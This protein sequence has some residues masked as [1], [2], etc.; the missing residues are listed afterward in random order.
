MTSNLDDSEAEAGLVNLTG[1][2]ADLFADDTQLELAQLEATVHP[3]LTIPPEIMAEIFCH[4]AAISPNKWPL[5]ATSVCTAWRSIASATPHLWNTFHETITARPREPFR[6]LQLWIF[7]SGSLPLDLTITVSHD[8]ELRRLLASTVS[9][10]R[11]VELFGALCFESLRDAERPRRL[12]ALAL[13][14]NI[15]LAKVDSD[16]WPQWRSLVI[17]GVTL[18]PTPILPALSHVTSLTLKRVTAAVAW[19]VLAH[20][21]AVKFLSLYGNHLHHPPS[22]GILTVVLPRVHTLYDGAP[23]IL[24]HLTLPGLRDLR[25]TG[26]T[27]PSPGELEPFLNRSNCT[28]RSVY[29]ED[30]DNFLTLSCLCAIPSV[31]EFTGQ[32]V[33]LDGDEDG[34]ERIREFLAAFAAG[35]VLPN[36]EQMTL[37][38]IPHGIIPHLHPTFSNKLRLPMSRLK[39][40]TVDI[41]GDDG[42]PDELRSALAEGGVELKVLFT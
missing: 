1:Q 28:L 10:W 15:P 39:K 34:E 19:Q 38:G 37:L 8:E 24:N 3:I 18:V 20:T 25:F 12:P 23:G 17:C 5:V 41:Y 13:H 6:L 22:F 9:R 40:L 35:T 42:V 30:C 36:V 32:V 2:L 21:P 26:F 33:T 29:M 14:G 4:A 31:V 7:R 27:L 11:R 16:S